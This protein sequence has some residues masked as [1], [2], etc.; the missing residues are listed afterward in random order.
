MTTPHLED[1][2][3][4]LADELVAPA[5]PDIRTAIGRRARVLRR[6]RRTRQAVGAGIVV[7]AA[8]AGSLAVARDTTPEAQTDWSTVY[9]SVL[10]GLVLDRDGWE[11]V[12]AEDTT[13]PLDE[14]A[15]VQVFQV[16]GDPEGARVVV[17]HTNAS[18]PAMPNPGEQAEDVLV[19]EASGHLVAP[20]GG[21]DGT[22]VIRWNPPGTDS[23]AEVEA[24]GLSRQDAEAF[25]DGLVLRDGSI[26]HPAAPDDEFG[27]TATVLPS[28][29]EEVPTGDREAPGR[30]LLAERPA[31]GPRTAR[32]EVNV[33]AT[34]PMGHAQRLAVV[35]AQGPSA[36]VDVMGRPAT[37]VDR[38]DGTGWSVVWQ[39]SDAT[40]AVI[41]VVAVAGVDPPTL[42]AVLASLRISSDEEWATLVREHPG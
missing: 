20:A 7:L 33:E 3:T 19:G 4:R 2:L 26:Q 24:T 41:D 17:H 16:P 13:V 25:A 27:F 42:D 14:P 34:G 32:A 22:Y 31:S 1:R 12:M 38:A 28:D 37:F 15:S 18:D 21:A 5:T 40:T 23:A 6:R 10:P 36:E 9:T 35:T 8:V 29:L 30:R 11:V 39:P